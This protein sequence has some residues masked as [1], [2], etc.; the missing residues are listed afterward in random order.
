MEYSFYCRDRPGSGALRLGLGEAHVA[1]TFMPACAGP[2][3]AVT[4]GEWS[5][6]LGSPEIPAGS[7][8][9][10]HWSD[11]LISVVLRPAAEEVSPCPSAGRSRRSP[12]RGR[13]SMTCRFLSGAWPSWPTSRSPRARG[14]NHHH[15]VCRAAGRSG[16]SAASRLL[17]CLDTVDDAGYLVDEPMS[18]SGDCARSA[19]RRPAN[20]A[21]TLTGSAATLSTSRWRRAMSRSF[22]LRT[23]RSAGAGRPGRHDQARSN[24]SR[25][26][27][28]SQAATKS[29]TNFSFA[30]SLA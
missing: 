9:P 27:T 12:G 6:Q 1:L 18:R 14:G 16:T 13:L 22:G 30:S 10:M 21:G 25:F 11:N 19:V 7:V 24:R 3:A 2:G 4:P 5:R 23:S 8:F 20:R 17:T 28:L 26:I 15:L 29:F